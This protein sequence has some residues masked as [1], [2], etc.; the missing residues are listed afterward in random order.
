MS[1]HRVAW[2]ITYFPSPASNIT[3]L[4]HFTAL[5][6]FLC[7]QNRKSEHS[8]LAFPRLVITVYI[9]LISFLRYLL[10]GVD[11]QSLLPRKFFHFIN[12]SSPT[13]RVLLNSAI[14][15]SMEL[16]TTHCPQKLS[17]RLHSNNNKISHFRY[18]PPW[19]VVLHPP[20]A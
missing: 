8:H 16:T 19:D 13:L 6:L 20:E 2:L 10:F 14:F 3:F 4:L 15:S 5:L 1:F 9:L 7:C 11:S 12:Y 17:N 18:C